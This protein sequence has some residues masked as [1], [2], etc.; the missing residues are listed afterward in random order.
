MFHFQVSA[1]QLADLLNPW[2]EVDLFIYDC[3]GSL[4]LPVS[5]L[6]CRA[7]ASRCG[8]FSCWGAGTLGVQALAVVVH[9]LSSCDTWSPLLWSIWDP[10]GPGIEPVYPALPGGYLATEPAGS[11]LTTGPPGRSGGQFWGRNIHS[12]PSCCSQHPR[13]HWPYPYFPRIFITMHFVLDSIQDIPRLQN[14]FSFVFFWTEVDN[15]LELPWAP[16]GNQ[17]LAGRLPEARQAGCVCV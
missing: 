7:L 3:F 1:G 11:L 15:Y 4:L 16:L 5:F 14:S 12:S 8:G 13:K 10:S 9:S 6:S 17:I 2:E